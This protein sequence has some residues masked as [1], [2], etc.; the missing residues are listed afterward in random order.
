VRL[1]ALADLI[2]T[3]VFGAHLT[4]PEMPRMKGIRGLGMSDSA[5]LASQL[6][7][8]FDYV[9]TFYHQE[10]KFD[11]AH[12][13]ERDLGQFDFLVSSE[14]FEHV[15]PPAERSFEVAHRLLKPH[16][17]LLMT[18]PYTLEQ[19][20][21]EH[22]PQL[23]DYTLATVGGRLVLVNSGTDGKLEIFDNLVFHGGDGSTLEM[24]RFSEK[25]LRE[26]LSGAG[27]GCVRFAAED[28]LPFGI[29]HAETWSLPIAARKGT[30]PVPPLELVEEYRGAKKRARSL[31]REL[32]KTRREFDDHVQFHNRTHAIAERDLAERTAWAQR[33]EKELGERTEWALKL[34]REIAGQAATITRLQREFEERTEW[35]LKLDG[36]LTEA[37]GR[38]DK[39]W[40]SWWTRVGRLVGIVR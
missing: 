14:V 12:P 39:L 29:V 38:I 35:A 28:Y 26:I 3:E 20:T 16:G 7:E 6:A 24:R 15:P 10:P 19:T 4:L 2:S 23:G 27:F 5:V 1:R 30:F 11:L 8:K 33:L 18:V 31:E 40:T 32:E 34:D 9:N 22:F 36:E 37:R 21:Q 13:D 25:S 17:L